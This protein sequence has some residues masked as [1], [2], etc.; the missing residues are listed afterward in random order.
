MDVLAPVKAL[1]RYQQGHR[2]LAI[3]L[4]VVKKF[5]DD[6]AGGLA[7][8]VA[9]YAFFSLFPLLLVFVTI[10]G[11]VLSGHPHAYESV[12]HSVLKEFPVIGPTIEHK[13]LRGNGLALIV[14]IAIALWA[15]LGVTQSAHNALDHIWAVPFKRRPNFLMAKLRGLGL[16]AAI[17]AMFVLSTAVSGVVT[18]GLGGAALQVAGIVLTLILNFCLF[19]VSF[20]L[21][22]TAEL[23]WR[24]LVPGAVL[25]AIFWLVL[26]LL[27]GDL[28]KHTTKSN[29]A[30]GVFAVVLALLAWLHLGAQLTIYAAEL[31]T[32][33]SRRLWPRSLIGPPSS[34]ADERAL[35]A[36][37]KA[38][39]RSDAQTVEV[40]FAKTDDPPPGAT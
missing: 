26:Q 16:L 1:D 4:A 11:Y 8:L 17:G 37:A 35:T 10:L 29:S 15:G 22:C 3:P 12:S 34:R 20:K 38:E 18:G 7:A 25:S 28:I 36:L 9:Y 32:V 23:S 24:S 31:N 21:L 27:G 30:Y 40:H 19:L 33:L 39:E 2:W 5:G 6:Q 14:G 13:K